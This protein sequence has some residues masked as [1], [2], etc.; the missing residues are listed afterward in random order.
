MPTILD[1]PYDLTSFSVAR[2]IPFDDPDVLLYVR[3]AY[4]V[5]QLIIFAAYYYT[6]MKVPY[7]L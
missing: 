3:I 7:T 6:S 1:E 2:K 5:V 4:V